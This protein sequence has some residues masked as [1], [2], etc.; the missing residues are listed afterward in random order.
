MTGKAVR[1][2]P[3]PTGERN[4]RAT[5]NNQSVIDCQYPLLLLDH[6]RLHAV[7]AHFFD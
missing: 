3:Y 2:F 5:H 4:L 1:L 6:A 7:F